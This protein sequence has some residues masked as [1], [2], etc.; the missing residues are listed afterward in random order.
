MSYILDALKKAERDR[1]IAQVPTLAT[2]HRPPAPAPTYRWVWVVAPIVVL[3]LAAL[4]WFLWPATT[5]SPEPAVVAVAPAATPAPP[6]A[7]VEPPSQTSPP[8][9]ELAP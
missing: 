9:A 1:H 6:T 4:A 8:S 7:A 2:V 5:P 3:N